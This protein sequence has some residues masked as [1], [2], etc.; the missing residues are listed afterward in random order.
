NRSLNRSLSRIELSP[1]ARQE[2]DRQ[3]SRLAGAQTS[4]PRIRQAID[5]AFVSGFRDVIWISVV[6]ALLSTASAQMIG[7]AKPARR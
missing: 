4:D 6:L 7:T 5:E 1:G 3:R 2:V